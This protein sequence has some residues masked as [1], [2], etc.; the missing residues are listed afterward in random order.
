MEKKRPKIEK[1]QVLLVGVLVIVGLLMMDM[2][3]RL[4][5]LYRLKNQL[6]VV[7]A[8][9]DEALAQNERLKEKVAYAQSDKAVDE[10]A[11]E[12]G[13]MAKPGD[14]VI[15]PIPPEGAQIMPTPMPTPTTIVA[16]NWEVWQ[17]L[18]FGE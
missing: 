8:Q 15:V 7:Q 18:F 5:E 12:Q 9:Y 16:E 2:N 17:V 14:V 6:E 4:S 10:W 13:H 3:S 1:K 11:R